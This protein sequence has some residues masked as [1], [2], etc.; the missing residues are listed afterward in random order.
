MGDK[1]PNQT[2][3]P[4]KN[5]TYS[6]NQDFFTGLLSTQGSILQLNKKYPTYFSRT[7]VNQDQA[8]FDR[9]L[10]RVMGWKKSTVDDWA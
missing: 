8:T 7:Q 10:N 5:M 4:K 6:S 9:Y 3:P 2:Y 1:A